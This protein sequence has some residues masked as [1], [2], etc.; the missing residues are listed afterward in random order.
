MF[1]LE[2]YF[3]GF[4]VHKDA[5]KKLEEKY[6]N[7]KPENGKDHYLDGYEIQEDEHKRTFDKYMAIMEE[8]SEAHIKEHGEPYAKPDLS[9]AMIKIIK[10]NGDSLGKRKDS[11]YPESV[12][13]DHYK[14]LDPKLK[15]RPGK[16]S[17]YK[18]SIN[19]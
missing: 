18:R 13:E 11:V 8:I 16:P 5:I 15:R 14:A 2:K 3:E 7:L 4:W 12:F 10:A 19:S 9:D 1:G 6:P 17:R